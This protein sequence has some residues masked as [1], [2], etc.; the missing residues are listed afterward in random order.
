MSGKTFAL[1]V[2]VVLLIVGGAILTLMDSGGPTDPVVVENDP[3]TTSG[4]KPEGPS[5]VEPADPEPGQVDSASMVRETATGG[6]REFDAT[7]ELTVSGRVI[8]GRTEKPLEGGEVELLYPDGDPFQSTT[9]DADGRYRIAVSEGIP[10][11]VDLRA[12]ADGFATQAKP[13]HQVSKSFRNLTVDFELRHWFTIEGRVMSVDGKPVDDATVEIRSLLPMYEDDW[14][15]GDTDENGFYR[16]EEI[17][18]LP[19]SG[20]DVWA[21]SSG[22]IPQVKSNLSI[23]EDS[24]TLRVDFEVYHSLLISGVVVSAV[25]RR[26]LEDAEIAVTSRDPEFVDDGEEEITEED[27]TFLLELDAV[28]YEGLFILISAEEH[29]AVEIRNVPVPTAKGEIRLG[30]IM[31]PQ[32]VQV[33]GVVVNRQD[34]RPVQG[35]DITIYAR[36]APDL[37]EG[38]YA[39]C[40]FINDLG[41]FEIDLEA[42]P[43]ESAEVYVEA[44][45]CFPLRRRLDI[46]P[47]ALQY[48][49]RLE[50]DPML[51]LRGVVRRKVDGTPVA[52]A[53]VRLIV[54]EESVNKE[55]MV[56]RTRANGLYMLDLPSGSVLN[57]AIVIEYMDQRFPEGTLPTPA[58][59]QYEIE[60]DFVVD[61]PPMG[62]R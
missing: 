28:P 6:T 52:G 36:G 13:G 33:T 48:E 12:W 42:T 14:D 19:R 20:F 41:R 1:F 62:R 31:L 59:G 55:S 30:E 22:Y 18:D 4:K 7:G 15:D 51:K 50:V 43:P 16:I 11:V 34:G 39:D 23:A 40:E 32:M 37:D 35:G 5:Q 54:P 44:D 21:T 24:D 49:I 29:S 25:D 53:R 38:D 17:E 2:V 45:G 58:A 56:A 3:D 26:P 8:D 57:Y 46:P 9:T 47:G 61:L 10:P 27:G 60:K